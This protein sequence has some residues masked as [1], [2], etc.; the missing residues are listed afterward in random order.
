VNPVF[1]HPEYLREVVLDAE[2]VPTAEFD[3]EVA[4]AGS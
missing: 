3:V 1:G 2:N 4:A